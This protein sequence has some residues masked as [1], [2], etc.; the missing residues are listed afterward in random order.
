MKKIFVSEWSSRSGKDLSFDLRQGTGFDQAAVVKSARAD[1]ERLN[2]E[3]LKDLSLFV[4]AYEYDESLADREEEQ[5]HGFDDNAILFDGEQENI[6]SFGPA[7]LSGV[8]NVSSFRHVSSSVSV[9]TLESGDMVTLTGWDGKRWK[10]GWPTTYRYQ[11]DGMRL[12]ELDE[13]SF[14]FEEAM[15]PISITFFA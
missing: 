11:A 2:A 12:D 15:T 10:E 7:P 3:E 1:Y 8:F 4:S 14:E 13:D 5:K 6:A 9:A